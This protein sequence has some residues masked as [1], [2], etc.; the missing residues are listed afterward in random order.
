[1]RNKVRERRVDLLGDQRLALASPRTPI[2]L[3]IQT[4]RL[5]ACKRLFEE[6]PRRL[7]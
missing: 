2:A 7:C 5:A 3:A 6:E 4:R 1:V